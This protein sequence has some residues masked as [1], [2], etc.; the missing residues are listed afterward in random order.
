VKG[1]NIVILIALI[2]MAFGILIFGTKFYVTGNEL[3]LIGMYEYVIMGKGIKLLAPQ[4]GV[5]VFSLLGLLIIVIVKYLVQKD[6]ARVVT[7]I[8]TGNQHARLVVQYLPRFYTMDMMNMNTEEYA[9]WVWL[10][11]RLARFYVLFMVGKYFLSLLL[12][13]IVNWL[14]LSNDLL[15]NVIAWGLS[16]MIDINGMVTFIYAI[17]VWYGMNVHQEEQLL[18]IDV[19]SMQAQLRDRQMY[20]GGSTL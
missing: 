10:A 12:L 16:W 17:V 3:D 7:E 18:V 9:F 8:N 13:L 15:A 14:G 2:V 4:I 20:S 1:G 19:E 11:P 6:A 5:L